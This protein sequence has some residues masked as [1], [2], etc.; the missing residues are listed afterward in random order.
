MESRRTGKKNIHKQE[1]C[2][3][4]FRSTLDQNEKIPFRKKR[5]CNKIFAERK[6]G[7]QCKSQ[8]HLFY[9]CLNSPQKPSI[10]VSKNSLRHENIKQLLLSFLP[11][12]AKKV[13]WWT[14]SL[15]KNLQVIVIENWANLTDIRVGGEIFSPRIQWNSRVHSTIIFEIR[16]VI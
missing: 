9:K 1:I 11:R 16:S 2:L 5:A 3:K 8:S 10:N 14:S 6:S 15:F 13:K 7:S 12:R 4:S